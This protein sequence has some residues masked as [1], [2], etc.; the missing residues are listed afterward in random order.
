MSEK[1]SNSAGTAI[2]SFLTGALTGALAGM[3]FAI[4][5]ES[6]TNER[7]IERSQIVGADA[8]SKVNEKIDKMES[9]IS[10]FM[11]EVRGRLAELERE[12]KQKS[13]KS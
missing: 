3:I 4:D 13:A 6:N 10:D 1:S 5:K 7:I 11:E 2:V 12:I 9:N 8:N